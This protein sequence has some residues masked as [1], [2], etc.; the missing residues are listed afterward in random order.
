[1]LY[2]RLSLSHQV[3]T[4]RGSVSPVAQRG[5]TATVGTPR[6]VAC[7]YEGSN[8][9]T[10]PTLQATLQSRGSKLLVIDPE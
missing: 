7:L 2:V 5:G 1:M 8:D 9:P 3:N 6:F 10:D 4:R